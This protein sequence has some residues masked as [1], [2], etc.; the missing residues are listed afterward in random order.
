[1]ETQTKAK[2]VL[3][4]AHSEVSFKVKH[5]MISTVTGKFTKFDVQLDAGKED[6]SDGKVA[7]TIEVVGINTG[8]AQRDGHLKS[9][10]F[11]DAEKYPQLKFV[12]RSFRKSD[13]KG[14]YILEG[15]L[16]IKDVTKPIS[17]P[18]EYGGTVRDP[19]GNTKIAF[20]IDTRINRKEFGL[21]WNAALETGGV[22]VGE[23]VRI[24]AEIQLAEQAQ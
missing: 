13:G 19:W 1:M 22:L 12:S 24:L 17:I 18:V 21:G 5:L 16:T 15:D 3:D 23:E 14:D 10:D 6:L 9:P 7:V 8:D 2:W 4:P 11:F 20:S